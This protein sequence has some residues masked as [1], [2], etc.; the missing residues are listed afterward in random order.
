MIF[1]I[2]PFH[3]SIRLIFFI[4]FLGRANWNIPKHLAHFE[5]LP[6]LTGPKATELRVYAHLGG[7][8]YSDTPFFAVKLYPMLLPGLPSM[9]NESDVILPPLDASTNPSEDGLVAAKTWKHYKT[10]IQ[11]SPKFGM[12]EILSLLLALLAPFTHDCPPFLLFS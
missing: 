3:S 4:F 7:D 12:L 8:N 9:K 2:S 1:W 10:T 6:A 11:L 5:F